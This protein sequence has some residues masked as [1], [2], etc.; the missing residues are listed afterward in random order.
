MKRGRYILI[1]FLIIVVT[2]SIV[3]AGFF[4]WFKKITGEASQ[5]AS[6]DFNISVGTGSA[7]TI[8]YVSNISAVTLLDGPSNTNLSFNFS[9]E[10]ADGYGN[11]NADSA[12]IN[13]TNS[14]VG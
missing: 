14:G 8:T 9:V 1:F 11:L 12:R 4:D 13:V 3:S 7:P 2:T 6:V 10:D 5:E